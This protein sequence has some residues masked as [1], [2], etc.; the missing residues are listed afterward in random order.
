MNGIVNCLNV[1]LERVNLKKYEI[2]KLFFFFLDLNIKMREKYFI[3]LLSYLYIDTFV[4]K[5]L[6]TLYVYIFFI[7][8]I[9]SHVILRMARFM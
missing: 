2:Y 8:V 5:S 9:R 1:I 4:R 7:Y 6:L 3:N